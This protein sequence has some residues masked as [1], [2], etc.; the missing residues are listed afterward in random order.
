MSIKNIRVV[1]LCGGKG[2]RLKPITNNIPKPLIL[3]K[4]K[5]ILYYLL[6]YFENYGVKNFIIATGY[7]SEKIEK[8]FDRNHRNLKI[9]IVNSGEVDIVK[10]VISVKHLIQDNFILCYGDTLA[11]IK[12]MIWDDLG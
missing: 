5:P 1:I 9:E 6:K 12:R 2:T 8:Y 11:N 7:H 10:R 4:G 3:I